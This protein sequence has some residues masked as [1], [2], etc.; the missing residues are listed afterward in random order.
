[1]VT[2]QAIISNL[3]ILPSIAKD[4]VAQKFTMKEKFGS[5]SEGDGQDMVDS[6][7]EKGLTQEEAEAESLLQMQ[8][9][10]IFFLGG[11]TD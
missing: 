4:I 9:N 6:F 1:V 2:L 11:I 8:E 3:L 7:I 5:S 10:R